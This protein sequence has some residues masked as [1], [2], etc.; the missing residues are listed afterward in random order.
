VLVGVDEWESLQERLFWL[1]Q[2]GIRESVAQARADI[3]EG[4]TA[5][6][7]QIREEFAVPQRSL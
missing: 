5:T 4:R 6:Q 1:S 3:S 7:E 2:P